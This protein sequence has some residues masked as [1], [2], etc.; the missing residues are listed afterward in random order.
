[1]PDGQ[2][3]AER[4]FVEVAR[5]PPLPARLSGVAAGG[6]PRGSG[7]VVGEVLRPHERP[8]HDV[9][10]VQGREP[11]YRESVGTGAD[12]NAVDGCP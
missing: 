1:M 11:E 8:R 7:R 6:A 10:A 9:V 5:D 3:A 12:E 2:R 4:R